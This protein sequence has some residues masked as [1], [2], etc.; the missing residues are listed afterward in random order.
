MLPGIAQGNG[1]DVI[2][3]GDGSEEEGD[4]AQDEWE[5]VAVGS[6]DET[7]DGWLK[8]LGLLANG[9]DRNDTLLDFA[10]MRCL[11]HRIPC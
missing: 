1:R 5:E 4:G 9:L 8:I 3:I 6:K 7:G 10:M 11:I 2:V